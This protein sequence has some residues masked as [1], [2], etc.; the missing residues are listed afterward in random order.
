MTLKAKFTDFQQLTRSRTGAVPP[1]TQVAI[2]TIGFELLQ[3]LFPVRKGIRLLGVTLSSLAPNPAESTS[4]V[5]PSTDLTGP[6]HLELRCFG[7]IDRS[8]GWAE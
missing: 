2:E 8:R 4:F 1:A 5:C 6:D 7:V 3:S